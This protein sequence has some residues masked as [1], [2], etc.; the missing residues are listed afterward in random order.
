ML[1]C[2][3]HRC[4]QHC[5][6][7]HDHSNILCQSVVEFKCPKNHVQKRK[8]HKSQ[9]AVCGQCEIGNE[10]RQ[11][12]LEADLERQIRREKA[13]AKYDKEMVKLDRELRKER[14]EAID[15]STDAERA[16]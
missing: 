3:L 5:H 9:P 15:S 10:R 13:R 16:R 12:Q 14:E 2:G 11:N 7:L 6:K 8:C 4:P 1:R